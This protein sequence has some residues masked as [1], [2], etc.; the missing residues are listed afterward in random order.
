MCI[1]FADNMFLGLRYAG[2]FN[3]SAELNTYTL[4]YA[5]SYA[6]ARDQIETECERE[7]EKL[8]LDGFNP[9]AI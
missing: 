4:E 5:E 1:S 8:S 9:C 7:R 6:R 2:N 3:N